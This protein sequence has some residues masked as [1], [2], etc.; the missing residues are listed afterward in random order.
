MKI[1]Q[2][3][4]RELPENGDDAAITRAIIALA[5]SLELQVVAEGVETQEQM[6]F[7]KAQHCDAIQGYL[8]SRPVPAEHFARML[9]EHKD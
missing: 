9:R 6:D 5:H 4:I 3:F 7:L 1:D 2:S 8:I